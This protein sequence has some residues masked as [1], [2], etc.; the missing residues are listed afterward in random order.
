MTGILPY[1]QTFHAAEY[2]F[3]W[4]NGFGFLSFAELIL[5]SSVFFHSKNFFSILT[6]NKFLLY[7]KEGL[8]ADNL[9]LTYS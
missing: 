6:F 5:C 9:H 3:Q 2:C 4:V 1:S 7:V 8:N